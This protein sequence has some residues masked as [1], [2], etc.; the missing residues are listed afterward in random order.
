MQPKKFDINIEDSVLEDLRYRLL[1]TR[2]PSDNGQGWFNGTSLSYMKDLVDYWANEYDWRKAEAEINGIDNFKVTIDGVEVHYQYIRSK[3][4]AAKAIILTHGWPDSFYRF[5]KVAPLL[6]E[7]YDV[8]V[9]SVPGYGFSGTEAKNS[10]QVADLWAKL[11]TEVL[12]YDSFYATGGD[13]GTGVVM[14]LADN[15]ANIV[16]AIHLT[17]VGWNEAPVG[18]VLT[19]D[20]KEFTET[21][22]MWFMTEGAYTMMHGTKPLTVAYGLNDSPA[23]LAAWAA[24]F[25]NNGRDT[26]YVDEAFGGRDAFLTNLTIYW[27][28]QTA[29]SAMQMYKE[30]AAAKWGD[31]SGGD[32]GGDAAVGD[33]NNAEAEKTDNDTTPKVPAAIAVFANDAVFPR[34]WAER[35]GLNVKRY[36]KYEEGGHFA[37]MDAADLYAK[38]VSEA[39]VEIA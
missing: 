17:D 16:K 6:A 33:W 29:G 36:K 13:V 19:K 1:H 37:A 24:S 18:A 12:G 7:N 28:T 10:T 27:A 5:H 3:K 4:A 15:H 32:W 8:V 34:E 9:P 20:E 25:A 2:F 26:D 21:T 35:Q 31:A 14:A 30:D 39:F 38:D 23:G 22:G 11:M